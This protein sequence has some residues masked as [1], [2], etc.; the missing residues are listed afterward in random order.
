MFDASGYNV[1]TRFIVE[2]TPE[3]LGEAI[4]G[5]SVVYYVRHRRLVKIGTTKHLSRRLRQ[6]GCLW[7]D[8]LAVE[9]GGYELEAERH[10]EFAQLLHEGREHFRL[11]ESLKNHIRALRTS[12]QHGSVLGSAAS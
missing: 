4:S 10:R 8:V 5:L 2:P 9:L 1:N 6:L 7:A 3:S 12:A 11:G